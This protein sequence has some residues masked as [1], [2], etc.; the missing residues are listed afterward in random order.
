[1]KNMKKKTKKKKE[2]KG[3]IPPYLPIGGHKRF[4]AK[5]I[6]DCEMKGV[7]FD[8]IV[9]FFQDKISKIS[10][11]VNTFELFTLEKDLTIYIK[12][13]PK[14]FSLGSN[15]LIIRLT[16]ILDDGKLEISFL[17]LIFPK[18]VLFMGNSQGIKKLK[19]KFKQLLKE[20]SNETYNKMMFF[21]PKFLLW[22]FIKIR[23]NDPDI[24]VGVSI[25][26]IT[27]T[28]TV[29][30]GERISEFGD[31]ITIGDTKNVVNSLV[32]L[33]CLLFGHQIE[34]SKYRINFHGWNPGFIIMK[35]SKIL[36]KTDKFFREFKKIEQFVIGIYIIQEMV[37]IYND[38]VYGTERKFLTETDKDLI[39]QDS[40][41]KFN[42]LVTH[43]R[44]DKLYEMV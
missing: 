21:E 29:R 23:R 4:T 43:D 14:L 24:R 10:N 6:Y 7:K 1:M 17:I 31:K 9:D 37:N 33:M 8:D 19:K 32:I 35:N 42:L 3:E 36:F 13:A 12:D 34:T 11:N 5:E 44:L 30:V 22:M 38:W 26:N 15:T 25:R 40:K 18:T 41:K 27:N 39:N 28:T 16:K 20:I 2:E